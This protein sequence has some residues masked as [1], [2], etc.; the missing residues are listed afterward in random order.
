[1]WTGLGM[2]PR[3]CRHELS[4]A[5]PRRAGGIGELSFLGV[6]AFRVKLIH[7]PAVSQLLHGMNHQ[8]I[9]LFATCA[10]LSKDRSCM[11]APFLV[12]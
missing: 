11:L 1:M 8:R 9:S 7:R 6:D 5:V 10:Q 4:P 3:V 2:L 12:I